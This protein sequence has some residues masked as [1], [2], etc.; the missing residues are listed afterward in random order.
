MLRFG[1]RRA[2]QV[3]CLEFIPPVSRSIFH[4]KLACG[5]VGHLGS[6][7]MTDAALRT[8]VEAA[9]PLAEIDVAQGWRLLDILQEAGLPRPVAC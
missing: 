2:A 5:R 1:R 3:T 7:N 4:A 6:G 9:L 8:H